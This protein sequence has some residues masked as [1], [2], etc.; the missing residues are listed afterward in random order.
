MTNDWVNEAVGRGPNPPT[1]SD[2]VIGVRLPPQ[3]FEKPDFHSHW[4]FLYILLPLIIP[5]FSEI[6]E[7]KV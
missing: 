4:I 7:S 5:Y 3:T 6:I 1:G 2:V